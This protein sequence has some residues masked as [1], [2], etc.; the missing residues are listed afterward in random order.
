MKLFI[1]RAVEYIINNMAKV[2]Q[3]KPKT[4]DELNRV[5]DALEQKGEV[6]FDAIDRDRTRKSS[7]KK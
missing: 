3:F 5:F 6:M 7:Q 4:L 1:P 2:D